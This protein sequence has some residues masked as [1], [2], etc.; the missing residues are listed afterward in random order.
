[1]AK[2]RNKVKTL[3]FKVLNT[4]KNMQITNGHRGGARTIK[5]THKTMQTRKKNTAVLNNEQETKEPSGKAK[6]KC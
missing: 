1:M 4:L 6:G 5:D 3:R 2:R